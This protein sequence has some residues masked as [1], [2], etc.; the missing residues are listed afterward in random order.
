MSLEKRQ[1]I[2]D[3]AMK[4]FNENGFHGTPTSKIAK[5]A[6]V[7]VGTLFNY[8]ETKEDLIESIY[9]HIKLHSKATFLELLEEKDS[10]HD[11]MLSMWHAIITWG[12]ENPEEFK[13][14]ELFCHSP[15]RSTYNK[16][17]SLEAYK[18]FQSQII[19]MVVPVTLCEHY[20]EYVLSYI[21]QSI[22]A[23]IR[24]L[25]YEDVDDPEYFI[26]NAFDMLWHGLSYNAQTKDFQS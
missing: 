7:S 20:P 15:F 1:H 9:V 13:Y 3:S 25:V 12:I 5:K 14:L 26:Q 22:H 19:K 23:A 17:K 18:Q 4:L 16:E 6:K 8:F 21:D 24:Y 11:T 2:I 10:L